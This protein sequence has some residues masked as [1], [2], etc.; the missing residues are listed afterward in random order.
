MQQAD[1]SA[2]G[3]VGVMWREGTWRCELGLVQGYPVLRLCDG[4]TVELEHEIMPGTIPETAEVMRRAVLRYVSGHDGLLVPNTP[5]QENPPRIG[6]HMEVLT[7]CPYCRSCR[8]VIWG[9]RPGEDWY[10]CPDCAR[11]W[12]R[13]SPS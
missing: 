2:D 5:P 4:D 7:R 6:P 10:F 3:T 11:R 8:A 13:P 12:D 9:S 1:F